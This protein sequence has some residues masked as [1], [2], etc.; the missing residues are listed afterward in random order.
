MQIPTLHGRDLQE[1]LYTWLEFVMLKY[2]TERFIMPFSRV[3]VLKDGSGYSL[4]GS[5]GGEPF[6]AGRHRIKREVKAVTYHAMEVERTARGY[7]VRFLLD[8]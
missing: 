8:L 6:D 7:V 5:I 2:D 3:K 1:L 4:T